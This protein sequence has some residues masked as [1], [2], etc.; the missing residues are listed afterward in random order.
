MNI[1]AGIVYTMPPQK[2]EQN[3]PMS[4]GK[5]ISMIL[6]IVLTFVI[7]KPLLNCETGRLELLILYY[8]GNHIL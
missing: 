7:T 2:N 3:L 5:R 4:T 1:I 6:M 8:Y